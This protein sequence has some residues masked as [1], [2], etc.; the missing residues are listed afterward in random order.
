MDGFKVAELINER[1]RIPFIF[2]TSYTNKTVIEKAK[3]TRPMGYIVKPFNEKD[4]YSSIEI[5][6]YN[7]AQR[8]KPTQLSLELINQQLLSKFTQKEYEILM[9]IYDGRTNQQMCDKHFV[10]I[11]TIKTH[12][13]KIYEKLDVHTRAKAIAKVRELSNQ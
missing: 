5:A 12:V 6:L 4:L 10:S 9:D 3:Y 1:Y 11:N 8:N 13:Q 7:H 2:L